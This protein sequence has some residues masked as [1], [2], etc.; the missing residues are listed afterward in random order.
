MLVVCTSYM[1]LIAFWTLPIT[2]WMLLIS[3]WMLQ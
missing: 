3:F 2:S 1:L